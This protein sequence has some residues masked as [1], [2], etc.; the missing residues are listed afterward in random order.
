MKYN[1]DKDGNVTGFTYSIYRSAQMYVS[2][3]KYCEA[4]KGLSGFEGLKKAFHWYQDNGKT[5]GSYK[6]GA[7]RL[8]TFNAKLEEFMGKNVEEYML[9]NSTEVLG[10]KATWGQSDWYA[11]IANQEHGDKIMK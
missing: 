7:E 3:V 5:S 8:H 2:Y 10:N 6:N 4:T 1:T 11:T 9:E